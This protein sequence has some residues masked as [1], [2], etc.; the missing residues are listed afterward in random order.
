MSEPTDPTVNTVPS[1]GP[2]VPERPS[3]RAGIRT[4]EFWLTLLAI[5][6]SYFAAAGVIPT[7]GW[8]AQ[9][10]AIAGSVLAALG[11][12]ASRAKAKSGW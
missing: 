2:V 6:L 1:N 4:T 7:T 10:A 12:S 5:L 3:Q 9:A 11:Y 8:I